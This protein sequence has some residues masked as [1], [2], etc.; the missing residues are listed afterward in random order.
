MRRWGAWLALKT[1]PIV[2]VLM[3]WQLLAHSGLV[4][5]RL[6]PDL[7]QIGSAFAT[8]VTSGD[9][10]YHSRF[11][12]ERTLLAFAIAAPAGI[13]LGALLA[14]SRIAEMLFEPIFSFGYP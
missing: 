11:T 6:F 4:T 3:A 13:V 7:V 12:L 1:Y 5:P 2:V 9:W 8:M 10:L 14:R